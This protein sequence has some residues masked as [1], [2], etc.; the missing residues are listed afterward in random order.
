VTVTATDAVGNSAQGSGSISVGAISVSA[1]ALARVDQ[2][3]TIQAGHTAVIA[4]TLSRAADV[5]VALARRR[6]SHRGNHKQLKARFSAAGELT[7]SG[8]AGVNHVRV[9]GRVGKRKL[10]PGTYRATIT[11]VAGGLK[12]KPITLSFVITRRG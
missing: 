8:K 6:V 5:T 4:F 7:V 3:E 9:G 11:A 1:G 10:R 2:A 12:S